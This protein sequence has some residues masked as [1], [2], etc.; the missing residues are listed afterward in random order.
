[1]C[2]FREILLPNNHVSCHSRLI[3]L[4]PGSVDSCKGHALRGDPSKKYDAEFTIFGDYETDDGGLVGRARS[5]RR[6]KGWEWFAN[7]NL[8]P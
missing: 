4:S 5:L 7:A 8:M 1:M 6:L 3:C 2:P